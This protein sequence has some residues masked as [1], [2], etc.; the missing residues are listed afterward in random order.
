MAIDLAN[1]RRHTGGIKININE[2]TTLTTR[3]RRRCDN[4]DDII[5]C[6]LSVLFGAS[7]FIIINNIVIVTRTLIVGGGTESVLFCRPWSALCR[8]GCDQLNGR[9]E[10]GAGEGMEWN[11]DDLQVQF[12]GF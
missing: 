5:Y 7:A 10:Q 1:T 12:N 6:I 8:H 11:G 9:E 3:R 4:D 2:Y